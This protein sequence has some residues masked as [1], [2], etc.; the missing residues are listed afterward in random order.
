MP[1]GSKTQ[2]EYCAIKHWI[3]AHDPG[4]YEA[5]ARVCMEGYLSPGRMNHGVTFVYPSKKVRDEIKEASMESFERATVL[6]SSHILPLGLKSGDD[7]AD[8]KDELGTKNEKQLKFISASSKEVVLEGEGG[9]VKLKPASIKSSRPIAVWEVSSGEMPTDGPP[10]TWRRAKKTAVRGGGE[11]TSRRAQIA[12]MLEGEMAAQ[13]ESGDLTNNPYTAAMVGLL[14]HLKEHDPEG[15]ERVILMLDED[16]V[17]SFYIAVQPYK[18]GGHLLSNNT[19]E[20]WGCAK[21]IGN[22]GEQ[23]LQML[24]ECGARVIESRGLVPAAE[25]DQFVD[26]VRQRYAEEPQ[27]A[28]LRQPG[29]TAAVALQLAEKNSVNGKPI[30][31]MAVSGHHLLWNDE[32]RNLTSAITQSLA[33]MPA[34]DRP[35][36]WRR[37][38]I[39]FKTRTGNN[40]E[41]ERT[42]TNPEEYKSSNNVNPMGKIAALRDIISSTD[43]LSR[44][45][46][47]PNVATGAGF[48]TATSANFDYRGGGIR[49]GRAVKAMR[50]LAHVGPNLSA[51]TIIAYLKAAPE[52]LAQVCQLNDAVQ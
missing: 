39:M 42:L 36:A 1:V 30:Y 32:L 51:S 40:H 15:L 14:A 23:Y 18:S 4:L 13:I 7:F 31:P 33:S 25:Y 17:P 19:I 10:F 24:R 28:G 8:S 12:N 35:A 3:E 52:L 2:K 46:P 43:F 47:D 41:S 38:V 21:G 11:A 50:T 9:P 48:V 26:S 34:A 29:F 16:P 49:N 37:A 6:I 20:S 22:V 5:I 45:N 44:L 27:A